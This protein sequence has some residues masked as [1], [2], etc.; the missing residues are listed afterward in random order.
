MMRANKV[1]ML[2]LMPAYAESNPKKSLVFPTHQM[3]LP[4]IYYYFN[5]K[6]LLSIQFQ[7]FSIQFQPEEKYYETVVGLII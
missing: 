1:I 7:H 3:P 4:G 5:N 2:K 6:T